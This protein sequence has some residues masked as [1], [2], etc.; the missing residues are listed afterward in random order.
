M[1][2]IVI[3]YKSGTSPMLRA[4]LCSLRRHTPDTCYKTMVVMDNADKEDPELLELRD[5]F[6]FDLK[7][8]Q[9]DVGENRSHGAMLDSVIPSEIDTEYFMTLDSDCF[10]VADGWIDGL[11]SMLCDDKKIA[12]ILHPWAPPPS[13]MKKTL[14]ERRVRIQHCWR[15]THVACQ[16]MRTADFP[17]LNTCYVAGDDT[18]LDIMVKAH[19]AGWKIDGYKPTR[20]PLLKGKSR[21]TDPEFNRY[22]GVVYGD[23]VY[24]HGSWTLTSACGARSL[25]EDDFSRVV[26][27][28]LRERGA[29]FMLD[30]AFSYRY[31]FDREEEVAQDKMKR[32]FWHL[33]CGKE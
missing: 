12:G 32:L 24:H 25:C 5:K 26:G 18:G 15:N 7:M 13:N 21:I 10:P 11:K 23:K 16:I 8:V 30:E 6:G 9:V 27:K 1:T 28:V 31:K 22:V 33:S 19:V 14:L 4:N 3:C 29:E 17:L 20:C 2:T